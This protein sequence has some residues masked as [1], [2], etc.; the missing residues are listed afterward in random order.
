MPSDSYVITP[1]WAAGAGT[2]PGSWRVLLVI[3]VGGVLFLVWAANFEIE[4]VTTGQGQVVPSQQV[5]VMQSLED[6]ILRSTQ[7][8]Q[9]AEDLVVGTQVDRP[10]F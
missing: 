1:A 4:E 8:R 9:K 6:G 5:Q 10:S 7:A 3:A 2:N